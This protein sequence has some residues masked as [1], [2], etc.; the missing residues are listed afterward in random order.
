MEGS[1]NGEELENS[2]E[3]GAALEVLFQCAVFGGNAR[4]ERVTESLKVV[5]ATRKDDGARAV[6]DGKGERLGVQGLGN[7]RAGKPAHRQHRGGIPKLRGAEA[8]AQR[9]CSSTDEDGESKDVGDALV[10]A[11]D[12]R[13]RNLGTQDALGVAQ[14]HGRACVNVELGCVQVSKR[15]ELREGNPGNRHRRRGIGGKIGGITVHQAVEA[16]QRTGGAGEQI[17][18]DRSEKFTHLRVVGAQ[19]LRVRREGQRRRQSRAPR[20]PLSRKSQCVGSGD[21]GK[22]CSHD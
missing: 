9:L 16:L 2:L 11:G 10:I 17:R 14:E 18:S 20:G 1:C 8:N 3:G 13:A 22:K 7:H 21:F 4:L 15:T 19:H 6:D 5:G 12:P